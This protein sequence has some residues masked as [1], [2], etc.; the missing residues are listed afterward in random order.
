MGSYAWGTDPRIY[1]YMDDAGA[2][3][4]TITWGEPFA[5]VDVQPRIHA[6]AQVALG[7]GV[8]SSFYGH[9]WN[10]RIVA[11][12]FWDSDGARQAKVRALI[13]HLQRGGWIAFSHDHARTFATR[14]TTPPNPGDA[15][16]ATAGNLFTAL[17][18]SGTIGNADH[19][20]VQSPNPY[21]YAEELA[22]SSFNSGT[23]AISLSASHPAKLDHTA[24][25]LVRWA[26]FFPRL[27]LRPE[28]RGSDRLLT[29]EYHNAWT[30]DLPL[31]TRPD[32]EHAA[33]AP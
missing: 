23:G 8:S 7:F 10:V 29:D 32:L 27:V 2:S 22:V 21:G 3:L 16:I 6:D 12:R 15:T 13:N 20:I 9:A 28:A 19:L 5:V 26:G 18:A 31:M 24:Y 25:T 14:A 17:S 1:A 33:V 11:E 30:L 4:T